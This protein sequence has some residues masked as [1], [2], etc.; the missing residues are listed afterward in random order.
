MYW[1]SPKHTRRSSCIRP[2]DCAGLPV[3]QAEKLT[4]TA[5]GRFPLTTS[6]VAKHVA[7][8]H[9][10]VMVTFPLCP[11]CQFSFPR[12]ATGWPGV[13]N[14]RECILSPSEKK[15]CVPYISRRP[16]RLPLTSPL[17]FLNVLYFKDYIL[18]N[19]TTKFSGLEPF[20]CSH[21][22]FQTESWDSED[23]PSPD[24]II[25]DDAIMCMSNGTA[26]YAF[27]HVSAAF[28]FHLYEQRRE[29]PEGFII[30]H[31]GGG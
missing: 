30:P 5:L 25:G 7:P 10:E 13:K 24:D 4:I 18:H 9:W 21:H 8:I 3:F 2:A 31:S 14:I 22:P 23:R 26:L 6:S 28:D 15:T 11:L 29:Q 16:C 19:S 17:H 1:H 12:M 20:W 27:F